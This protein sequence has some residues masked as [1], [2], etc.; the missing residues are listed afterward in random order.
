M[1]SGAAQ[2]SQSSAPFMS[3]LRVP[4]GA[5]QPPAQE[6]TLCGQVVINASVQM[7]AGRR[8]HLSAAGL[9]QAPNVRELSHP[10][11]MI[12]ESVRSAWV[13]FR[14]TPVS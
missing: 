10:V 4:L 5:P 3:P 9:A 13:R 7:V 12:V 11:G 8:M 6:A 1:R 2:N 14:V